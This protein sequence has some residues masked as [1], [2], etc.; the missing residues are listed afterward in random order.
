MSQPLFSIVT[1]TYNAEGVIRETM[2]SVSGQTFHDYEHVIIDGA[3]KDR[4]LDIIAGFKSP[5]SCLISEPDK[6]LYDAMNKA[7]RNAR[8]EY[9]IFLNA[10]D[11][12]HESRTL[13]ALA[14][15]IEKGDHPDI[16][17][18]ET[19]LVD[20]DYN[21]IGMRR[22]KTPENLTWKSF[23]NGMLV[24]HQAFIV[25]RTIAV[26]YDTAYRFSADFD[27]CIRCMKKANVI[28]NSR[29]ILV[30]YLNEGLTTR[31]HKASLK[32]RFSIMSKY[33]G[34]IPVSLYHIWFAVRFY[35]NKWIVGRV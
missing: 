18:G 15:Q 33:Y 29:L 34:L 22:L 17:Y 32:E 16:I 9:L 2:E 30:D 5:A 8:G 20:S 6:G 19:A 13:G 7:I 27:W 35:Y 28:Y 21:F 14:G 3:S 10:G 1:V 25:K 4:T 12:F 23:R 11:T 26:E 24:C 31:N